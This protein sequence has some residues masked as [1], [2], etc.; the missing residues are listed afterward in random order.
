MSNPKISTD[1]FYDLILRGNKKLLDSFSPSVNEYFVGS[2][3]FFSIVENSDHHHINRRITNFIFNNVP[4][5]SCACGFVKN[6]S[7]Y[8]FLSP[9]ISGYYFLRLDIK[10]FFHSFKIEYIE[11]LLESFFSKEKGEFTYSPYDIALL[12]VSHKI[13]AKSEAVDMR[14]N[15]ILPIGFPSS[16]VI[17]N[18]IFRKIDILIQKYCENKKIIYTRYADDMLFSSFDTNY[19]HNNEF[20]REISIL[21]SL[22]SLK[23]N[24][25]KRKA[26]ENTIS[27]NGYTIQNEKPK[28]ALCFSS[29]EE[30]R[31]GSIRLSN[32]KLKIIIKMIY[33]LDRNMEP[34][35]IMDKLFNINYYKFKFR[36]KQWSLKFFSEYVNDQLQN[37]IKGYRSYLISLITYNNKIQ[38][39][40]NKNIQ[41][42]SYLVDKLNEYIK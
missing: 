5:N 4:L 11:S 21:I 3:I 39:V 41:K 35:V 22:L 20:E 1:F 17:S 31:V 25:N 18:I 14:G 40:T 33:L 8:D 24:K 6:T 36:G 12:S 13:S 34:I 15:H 19:I 23:L 2:D 42:Y 10:K 30:K 16:P 9:H 28:K 32:K 27:L 38:C 7:Y 26:C 37:K 29:Y